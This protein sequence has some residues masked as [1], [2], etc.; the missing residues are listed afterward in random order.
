[1]ATIEYVDGRTEE[2][3][4]GGDGPRDQIRI[5]FQLVAPFHQSPERNQMKNPFIGKG[6][7]KKARH[8]PT[9]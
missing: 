5:S 7:Y 4:L 6:K 9:T 3:N 2:V 1:M 8:L